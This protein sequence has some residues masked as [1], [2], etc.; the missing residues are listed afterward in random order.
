VIL[1][2]SC[3]PGASTVSTLTQYSPVITSCSVANT[4]LSLTNN[5]YH[6][7]AGGQEKIR[8]PAI[9]KRAAIIYSG[10]QS[11]IQKN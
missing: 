1:A 9:H 3:H 4:Q 8:R 6:Q 10:E 11:N 5:Q 7:T 2:F